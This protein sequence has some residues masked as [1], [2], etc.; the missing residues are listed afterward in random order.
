MPL[1]DNTTTNEAAGEVVKTLPMTWLSGMTL[2]VGGG[3][4]RGV[5][6]GP[7]V[8]CPGASCATAKEQE[9]ARREATLLREN[10]S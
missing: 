7:I 8:Y 5:I 3:N 10:I 1:S 9:S 4:M 6:R 2:T